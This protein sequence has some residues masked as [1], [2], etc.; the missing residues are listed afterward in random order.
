MGKGT[1][2]KVRGMLVFGVVLLAAT[3]VVISAGPQDDV[4]QEGAALVAGLGASILWMRFGPLLRWLSLVIFASAFA[5][6]L[7]L[8]PA[9]IAW[10]GG[11]IAGMNFGAVWRDDTKRNREAG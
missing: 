7:L 11:F 6:W 10:M 1:Q 4:E 5:V 2:H 8:G 9:G 3:V